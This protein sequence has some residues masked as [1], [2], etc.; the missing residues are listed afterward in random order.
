MDKLNITMGCGDVLKISNHPV[1]GREP[2]T[3]LVSKKLLG[4]LGLGKDSSKA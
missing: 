3:Q 2:C 1:M 4:R